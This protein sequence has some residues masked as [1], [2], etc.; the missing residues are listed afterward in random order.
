MHDKYVR[1]LSERE[2]LDWL[3]LIRS[4]NVG[5]ITFN[6]LI[7]RFGTAGEALAALPGLARRGGRSRPIIICGKAAAQGE[8]ERLRSLGG[9]I[10]ALCE[11][12]Y[13]ENLRATDD[14]PPI[15]SLLGHAHLLRAKAVAV[16]GARNASAN[17]CHLAE[18]LS[19]DLSE[20]GYL[21]V[22]G[23]ARSIDAAAHRGALPGGTAAVMAGGIDVVYPQENESLYR[24]IRE[25]GVVLG[26]L[27]PGTQP[28]ARHFPRR[29][30]IISGL[31]LGV[32]VVEASMKSGSLITARF[33]M[34]QGREVFAV[35]GSPLDPRSH[36]PN[37]LIK[38]G[39]VLVENA[40]DVAQVLEPMLQ[41]PLAEN[42]EQ[43]FAAATPETIDE[44]DLAT[45][46]A[47]IGELLTTTPVSV[48][49]LIRQCQLSPAV[50]STALL[51]LELAGR[52]ERHPGNKVAIRLEV[53]A[54]GED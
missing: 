37:G 11:P 1:A 19:R 33:A 17:G 45:C 44:P 29:N 3:R 6:H 48:D 39:A 20:Q 10:L 5:P 41:S 35:P 12:D 50:V 46:R 30:R 9:R 28:Q 52:I 42:R 13:P 22:S 27:P 54:R 14:A 51:E 25:S 49:E 7:A 15:L 40:R 23:L 38:D 36:G 47:R 26:E 8:L 18:E 34:D 53:D 43:H 24:Q 21:V 31:A 32:V 2:R 4:E 16:V